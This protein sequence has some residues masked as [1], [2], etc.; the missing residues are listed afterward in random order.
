M[1]DCP[2]SRPP[3]PPRHALLHC[4]SKA[5]A[6]ARSPQLGA[7]QGQSKQLEVLRKPLSTALECSR[8][9]PRAA[10][11]IPAGDPLGSPAISRGCWAFPLPPVP[12]VPSVCPSG[13]SGRCGAELGH[14]PVELLHRAL[15]S[16]WY[17]IPC[18]L[19]SCPHPQQCPHPVYKPVI[20]RTVPLRGLPEGLLGVVR[21]CPHLGSDWAY[22][23]APIWARP[24]HMPMTSRSP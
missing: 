7:G 21:C 23:P 2:F 8:R 19:G 13:V 22:T 18:P 17:E 4:Y 15:P 14:R 16:L 9:M 6:G 12:H 24:W 1:P 3:V 20:D 11:S 10:G 5:R